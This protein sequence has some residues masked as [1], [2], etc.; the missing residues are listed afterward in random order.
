LIHYKS[1]A[2]AIPQDFENSVTM[3]FEKRNDAPKVT[4]GGSGASASQT[5]TQYQKYVNYA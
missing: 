1:F 2:F 3:P 4:V 5:G